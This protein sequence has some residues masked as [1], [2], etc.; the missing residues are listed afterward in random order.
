VTGQ[1]TFDRTVRELT[2]FEVF[3][4]YF[5]LQVPVFLIGCER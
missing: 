1:G 4:R 2:Q 3:T 5:P